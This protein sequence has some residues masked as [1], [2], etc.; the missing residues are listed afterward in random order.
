[1]RQQQDD[2]R[3]RRVELKRGSA[4]TTTAMQS[5]T[6]LMKD[7]TVDSEGERVRM[8]SNEEMKTTVEGW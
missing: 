4:E 6:K 1:V 5:E 7:N 2:K 3:L 8:G